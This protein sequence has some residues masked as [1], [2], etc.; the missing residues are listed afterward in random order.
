MPVG[1]LLLIV[2]AGV[3][4]WA[5]AVGALRLY[6]KLKREHLQKMSSLSPDETILQKRG[7]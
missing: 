1:N 7:R 6:F 5:V 3:V 2:A 4:L